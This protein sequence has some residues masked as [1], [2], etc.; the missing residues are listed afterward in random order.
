MNTENQTTTNKWNIFFSKK[1]W[2]SLAGLIF[3]IL[4][5]HGWIVPEDVRSNMIELIIVIVSA[6]NV[7]QGVADGFS[8][9]RT[10]GVAKH[11]RTV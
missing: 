7:G 3:G 1:F 2:V 8:R 4:A 10:S 5:A 11:M 9:G 6:Y